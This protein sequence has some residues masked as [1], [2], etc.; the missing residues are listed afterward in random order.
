M[1]NL[2]VGVAARRDAT[3][4]KLENCTTLGA[5]FADVDFK[6]TLE[7]EAREALAAFPVPPT[8]IVHSGGGLHV[9]YALREPLDLITDEPR[10]RALLERLAVYLRGDP[11][12]AEPARVLRVPGTLNRKPEYGTPRPVLLELCEPD[13]RYNPSELE[14]WL[15]PVAAPAPGAGFHTTTEP[16]REGQRH[17]YLFR[18]ARSLKSK[19][20]SP[21][22]VLAAVRVENVERCAPPLPDAEVVRQVDSAFAQTDRPGF[23][24]SDDRGA[25]VDSWQEWEPPLLLP[26]TIAGPSFPLAALPSPVRGHV[27][28]IAAHLQVPPDLPAMLALSAAAA[29]V[30][31]KVDVE[32]KPGWV[33]PMNLYTVT[34]L[35]S[36]EG[37]SPAF[38]EM[39][40]PLELWEAAKAEE[41]APAIRDAQTQRDILEERLK[42]IK[43]KA[44]KATDAVKRQQLEHEA[45]GAARDLAASAV[46]PPPRLLADDITP[47]KTISMLAEQGGRLMVAAPEGGLFGL[48]AGRYS[49][50]AKPNLDAYLK[51]HAGDTLR[52]DRATRSREFVHRPALTVALAVQPGVIHRLSDTPE[53]RENGLLARFLYAVPAS[54][55]GWRDPEHAPPINE[56]ARRIY[57]QTITA[58]LDLALPNEMPAGFPETIKLKCSP[59]AVRLLDGFRG[60][61]EPQLRARGRLEPIADWV[62]KLAGE[63]ARIAGLLHLLHPL[64][65][66]SRVSSDTMKAALEIGDYLL[67]H[68]LVAFRA[69]GRDRAFD[70]A[71]RVWAWVQ[72]QGTPE[73][74]QRDIFNAHDGT[75]RT[76]EDLRP[77][78]KI[79]IDLGYLRPTKVPTGGRPS[80]RY[81]VNPLRVEPPGCGM[82]KVQKP[83]AT[84]PSGACAPFA[85]EIPGFELDEETL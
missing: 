56:A 77:S 52:V 53:F 12:A 42:A 9:Y 60:A 85:P 51:A 75:Y 7:A 33:E 58:L 18:G 76:M 32:V 44:A 34:V 45:R 64:P 59:A 80:P 20:F 55:V 41:M 46:P 22:V 66:T 70:G 84:V 10:A 49:S 54:R 19:G 62:N 21:A 40:R 50:N 81:Q 28:S 67:E 5:V 2:Y 13:R 82:Q 72:D 1:D 83:R 6:Q 29:A 31:R 35:P 30:A 69:M 17:R 73:V 26:S 79:L 47:E 4:G 65:P 61:L 39:I 15:P 23:E 16:V 74:S 78:L 14:E 37:K 63:T 24:P 68:A 36:G 71:V 48:L 38:S 57:N 3:N 11:S 25:H 27:E 43:S 8:M